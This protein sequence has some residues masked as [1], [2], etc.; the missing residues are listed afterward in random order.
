MDQI[1]MIIKDTKR[2][3]AQPGFLAKAVQE[4]KEFMKWSI[5]KR[6][7]TSGEIILFYFY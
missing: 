7:L 1:P 2:K 4:E 3:M 6:S 5:R